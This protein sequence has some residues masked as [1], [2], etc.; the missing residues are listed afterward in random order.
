MVV[1]GSSDR[2]Q[3]AQM[4]N[5]HAAAAVVDRYQRH[6]HHAATAE[7]THQRWED[8]PYLCWAGSSGMR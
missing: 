3:T 2:E 1:E 8:V 6:D 7:D 4:E 5:V